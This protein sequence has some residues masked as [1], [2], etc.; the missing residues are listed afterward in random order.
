V[1]AKY[2]IS[3]KQSRTGLSKA[4][5]RGGDGERMISSYKIIVSWAEE[6]LMFCSTR[7]TMFGKN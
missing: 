7:L 2:L 3:Y 4:G 5:E 1:E 6:V